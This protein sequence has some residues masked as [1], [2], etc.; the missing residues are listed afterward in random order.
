MQIS[1]SAAA[2]LGFRMEDLESRTTLSLGK[3]NIGI[4]FH[5]LEK[6]VLGG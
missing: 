6:T 1:E 3:Q 2:L 4:H 5:V